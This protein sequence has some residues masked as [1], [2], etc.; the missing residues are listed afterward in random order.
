M[1]RTIIDRDMENVHLDIGSARIEGFLSVPAGACGVVLF[2]HGSGSGRLSP[3]NQFVAR[4]LRHGGVGTLLIDLLTAEEAVE[5]EMTARF[6]FAVDFLAERVTGATSWLRRHHC[7]R[8]L[9]IGYFG[10]STGAAAAL[11][12]AGSRIHDV[13]AIVSR[14]GRPDLAGE[15]LPKVKAPTLLIV[16]ELDTTVLRF[17]REALFEEPGTIEEASRLALQ[18][19]QCYLTAA[20]EPKRRVA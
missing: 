15:A 20:A 2:A 1:T 3:R 18:W 6:R 5:D 12:A 7:A 14:G 16:G 8:N 17:N 11:L 4:E 13:A 9:P 19:F 10:A